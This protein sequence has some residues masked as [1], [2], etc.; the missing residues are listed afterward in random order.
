LCKILEIEVD[1]AA[2]E[3]RAAEMEKMLQNFVKWNRGRPPSSSDEDLRYI[4]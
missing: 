4:G 3:E 1:M 2:L